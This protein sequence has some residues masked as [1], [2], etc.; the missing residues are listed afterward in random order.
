VDSILKEN[1]NDSQAVAMRASML[2][3][4]GSPEKIK[5]AVSDL[6]GLVA[7]KNDDPELRFLLAQALIADKQPDQARVH[8]EEAI[9]RSR[10]GTGAAAR[11]LLAQLMSA[12]GD[13]SKALAL[14]DEALKIDPN[15]YY[16]H[17]VRSSSLL[18]VGK[19]EDAKAELQ[20]ILKTVP[21]SADAQYQLGYLT[22]QEQNF[23]DAEAIFR[24]LQQSSPK[25]PR[26]VIGIVETLVAEGKPQDAITILRAAME[27]EPDRPEYREA[28]GNVFIRNK[29]YDEGLK[30]F[31]AVAAK[32][33]TP[34]ILMKMGEVY[35]LKGDVNSALDYF[36]KAKTAA[37]NTSAAPSLRCAMLLDGMGRR[38]EATKAY[39]DVL[40]ID[41]DNGVAMNNL[42]FIKADDG[43]DLDRALTLAQK[44]RQR[45]PTDPN[46][47]DTLGWIYVK[48]NLTDDAI[49][50]YRDIVSKVP[51]N[52]TYRYHLAMALMQKGD[53]HSARQELD[54]ALKNGPTPTEQG[55]I[56]DLI[57]KVGS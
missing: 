29:Q 43:S 35:R 44:A 7:K 25:D 1:P 52:P 57:A 42:A 53:K 41:P 19:R 12:K 31:Q 38:D 23:K 27:R 48:K 8:L 33:S 16:A 11:V 21:T 14:A 32:K 13:N 55:R 15:N 54:T 10:P 20:N 2:V 24:S 49:R 46:V 51:N 5:R 50:M 47:A 9:K 17:L 37:G 4:S 45:Y 26:A 40:R 6:Q 30:E 39:E 22:Y 34:E 36:Q 18:A 28:L 3:A 56:R